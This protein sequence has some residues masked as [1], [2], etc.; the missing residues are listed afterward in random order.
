[1]KRRYQKLYS[2]ILKENRR[3]KSAIF[4]TLFFGKPNISKF[5]FVGLFLLVFCFLRENYVRSWAFP[6]FSVFS[7]RAQKLNQQPAVTYD[8]GN[9]DLVIKRNKCC[10]GYFL[11]CFAVSWRTQYSRQTSVKTLLL[12]GALSRVFPCMIRHKLQK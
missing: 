6:A 7:E 3:P 4:P 10:C 5:K 12:Y 11:R 8:V 2:A 9:R 1:M